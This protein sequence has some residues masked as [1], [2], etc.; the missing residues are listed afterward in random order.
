MRWR[1]LIFLLLLVIPLSSAV[2]LNSGTILNTTGSNSSMSFS[3]ITVYTTLINISVNKI[4]IYNASYTNG[5]FIANFTDSLNWSTQN[6]HLDSSSYPKLIFSNDTY[7]NIS[8]SLQESINAS[9]SFPITKSCSLLS[10][11]SYRTVSGQVSEY[12]NSNAVSLCSSSRITL[13]NLSIELNT[14]NYNLVTISYND[15]TSPTPTPTNTNKLIGQCELLDVRCIIV[16][17][18]AGTAILAVLLMSILYFVAAYRLR[19]D[20]AST[21]LFFIPALLFMGTIFVGFSIIFAFVTFLVG[22]LVAYIVN[23]IFMNG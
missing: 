11:I 10:N 15:S 18:I 5:G 2:T 22:M 3:S 19:L 13:Y 21:I 14:T 9:F 12:I 1:V 20:F 7:K 6:S 23:R 17:Q 16:N 8:S 4:E